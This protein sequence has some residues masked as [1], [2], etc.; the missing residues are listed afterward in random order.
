MRL[1]KTF[2]AEQYAGALEAWAWCGLTG[3]VPVFTSLF[4]D[5]FL[6]GD[7]GW[8]FLDTTGG[9]L[10]RVWDTREQMDA[11]LSTEDGE[12]EYLLG[13]LAIGAERRGLVLGT[14]QVYDFVPPP[15][16]GGAFAVDNIVVADFVVSVNIAGQLH[17]QLKDLPPGTKISGL[18][19]DGEPPKVAPP[20]AR[21]K[22]WFRR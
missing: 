21:R 11:E 22:G 16:L 18:T 2:S 15:V 9:E 13:G 6:E 5:V 17:S 1:T 10:N 12:D 19:V 14:S 8:W 3:K 7:D 4:G 20:P